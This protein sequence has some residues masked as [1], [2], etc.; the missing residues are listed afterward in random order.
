MKRSLSLAVLLL[1]VASTALAQDDY[2]R[3]EFFG[4]YSVLKFD[5]L[6]DDT[7][8]AVVNDVLGEKN[9]R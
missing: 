8:N 2:K 5:N 4:G 1:I 9:R 6:G 3:W 7:G